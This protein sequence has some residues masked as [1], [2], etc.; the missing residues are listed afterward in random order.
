VRRAVWLLVLAGCIDA[1][2]P[3]V[4]APLTQRCVDEDSDPG[5]DVSYAQVHAVFDEYCFGCHTP[6]GR[7]PIGI[8]VGGLDLSTYDLLRAGGVV[9]RGD[10]VVPGRPCESVL[11]QKIRPSPPFG[12]RMPLNGP[13]FVTEDELQLLADWVAEGAQRD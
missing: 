7:S 9:S 1:F 3:Q 5:S 13:P 2:D 12:A 6:D 10:V 4:G 8:E 11:I